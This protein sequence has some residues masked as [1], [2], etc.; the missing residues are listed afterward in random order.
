MLAIKEQTQ[1][2]DTTT[3]STWMIF[4]V[5]NVQIVW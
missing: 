4:S 5:K 1:V 2:F 3:F